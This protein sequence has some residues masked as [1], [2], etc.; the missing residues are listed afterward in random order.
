MSGSTISLALVGNVLGL[1][2][3]TWKTLYDLWWNPRRFREESEGGRE[4]EA[5]R[6]KRNRTD[7]TTAITF[8]LLAVSYLLF[9]FQEVSQ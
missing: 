4:L 3:L 8:A 5:A 7:R 6:Q 1:L 2:T 9:I